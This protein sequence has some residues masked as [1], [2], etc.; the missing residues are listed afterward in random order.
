MA[1]LI[2]A[3]TVSCSAPEPGGTATS[4]ARDPALRATRVSPVDT[5]LTWTTAPSTASG[6]ALEYATDPKGPYTILGYLPTGV[7]S[8]QHPRLIPETT[9]YYRLR[10]Y[11]GPVSRPVTVDLPPGGPGADDRN[12]DAVWARPRTVR[13]EGVATHP[14]RAAAAAP[15]ALKAKVEQANGV[16][17]TWTD[18]ASDEDGYLLENRPEGSAAYRVVAV[19]DPDINSFGLSTLPEEKHAS[20]RV[21][22]FRYG[23]RSNTVRVT[24]GKDPGDG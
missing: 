12:D 21:R 23:E 22:A 24:T 14:L 10:A 1:L 6:Q 2:G 16:S 3:G 11:T 4:P 13:A 15:T 17:F 5:R 9:F 7:T 19:L 20:Y 18:H 8:Y